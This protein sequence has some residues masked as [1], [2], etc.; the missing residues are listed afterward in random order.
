[1]KLRLA[2]QRLV[3]LWC[4]TALGWR[5]R[6]TLRALAIALLLLSLAPISRA[7][8]P[9][10]APGLHAI[11][12][13]P[14]SQLS[15]QRLSASASRALAIRPAEWKHGE[16]PHFILHFFHSFIATPVSVEVEFYFRY[17]TADLASA[18]PPSSVKGQL[19]V[20]ESEND[21]RA[22][23]QTAALEPWTGGITAGNEL[24]VLRNPQ[25]KFKGHALGHEV[26]HFMIARL[27]GSRLPLWLEEGY[28]EDVSLR[29]YA[30]FYRARGYIAHQQNLSIAAYI[31][32]S[33]LVK[34]IAYPPENEID[35]FYNE[36]RRLVGF[37]GDFANKP[38]FIKMLGAAAQGE[39]FEPALQRAFGPRWLSLDDLE[40][41]FKQ[42]LER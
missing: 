38:Q 33:R 6:F 15:D 34:L 40:K 23:Q 7:Q 26:A 41:E 28:A 1:M 32:L 2:R 11:A 5:A 42:R 39:A 12:E 25:L 4:S 17:I 37:L 30:A 13:V 19:F 8:S 36:S 3:V 27:L 31:P 10:P 14:F 29:G 22:F 18:A 16:T 24:F 21:W 9:E 20:F 35:S